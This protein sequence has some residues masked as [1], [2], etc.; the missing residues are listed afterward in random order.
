MGFR[1]SNAEIISSG[2]KEREG[3]V[4]PRHFAQ[5]GVSGLRRVISRLRT[6]YPHSGA[7]N[8]DRR[9]TRDE[10]KRKRRRYI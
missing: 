5:I 1:I 4:L 6:N 8:G 3:F 2:T 7:K 10:E 9:S